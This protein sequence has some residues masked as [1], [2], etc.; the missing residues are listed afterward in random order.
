LKNNRALITLSLE[1]NSVAADGAAAL[2]DALQVNTVLIDL[3][4]GG[5][6]I[7]VDG[8]VALAKALKGNM[9]LMKLD[10]SWNGLK[11]EGTAA[12]AD[13]LMVNTTLTTVNL[14]SNDIDDAGAVALADALKVNRALV[15]VN[16]R[17]NSV[18][19]S[20]AIAL[21]EALQPNTSIM[22]FE[23]GDKNT[24]ALLQQ[25][26][27]DDSLNGSLS[28]K[29][30][31]DTVLERNRQQKLPFAQ[32]SLDLIARHSPVLK[33]VPADVMSVLAEQLPNEVI[34][35]FEQE[36]RDAFRAPPPPITTTT[37]NTTTT[38][39]TTTATTTTT[40]LTIPTALTTSPA[41][42]ATSPA[43]VPP[44]STQPTATAPDINALLAD[45][46]PVVALSRWIDGHENPVAALSWV[47]PASGHTLL[48]YAVAAQQGAV[49]RSLLA[50]GIDRTK[51]D[52]TNQT[53]AQLAQARADSSSSQTAAAIAALLQ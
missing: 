5:N 21:A 42:T 52:K 27:W 14:E 10:L 33:D 16:L 53:A 48:H 25:Y 2:A 1:K 11:K 19:S 44:V 45:P 4:L 12:L 15:S 34:A 47:D 23:Y 13:A 18:G 31:I 30:V 38:T 49:V 20:G 37:T 36:W 26:F 17:Y 9:A 8:S 40:D 28:P 32:A 29:E 43:S 7:G 39:T 24:A 41:A 46:N 35:V 50:R 22:N 3:E 6:H 51:A